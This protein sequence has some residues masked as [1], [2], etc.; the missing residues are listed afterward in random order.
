M[1]Q[2][3][4]KPPLPRAAFRR[5]DGLRLAIATA[6]LLVAL[7]AVFFST[8]YGLRYYTASSAAKAALA[9]QAQAEAEVQ[10]HL[11]AQA[12]RVGTIVLASDRGGCDEIRFDNFTGAFM[13]I[14]KVD[15][16]NRLTA[17]VTATKAQRETGAGLR[18]MLESFKK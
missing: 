4:L 8:T 6:G 5:D 9:A 16:G 3:K 10:A 14:V 11:D 12:R 18:G 17:S 15:C 2:R 1:L 13:S 7:V